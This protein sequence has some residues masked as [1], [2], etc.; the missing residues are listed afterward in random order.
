M[1]DICYTISMKDKLSTEG[2]T[3]KTEIIKTFTNEETGMS[4]IVNL[5]SKGYSVVL[6]D[7]DS[8][9]FF[10]SIRIFDDVEKACSYAEGVC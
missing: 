9:M 3:M 5:M 1:L 7:N 8:G 6:K 10:D 4:A 2:K